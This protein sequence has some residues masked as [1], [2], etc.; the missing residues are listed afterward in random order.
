MRSARGSK[1][2]RE[3]GGKRR[4]EV[5][6]I[7][8]AGDGQWRSWI[9]AQASRQMRSWRAELEWERGRRRGREGQ[10][11][12]HTDMN[13]HVDMLNG[14]GAA[15]GP[16]AGQEQHAN[17]ALMSVECRCEKVKGNS[18][19]RGMQGVSGARSNSSSSSSWGS[20]S[21]GARQSE[22]RS[23]KT[24]K[25]HTKP[26]ARAKQTET[27]GKAAEWGE[28]TAREREREREKVVRKGRSD[29][30][31]TIKNNKSSRSRRCDSSTFGQAAKQLQL[32]SK[33]ANQMSNTIAHEHTHMH[34][35]TVATCT[36][37][38]CK[39]NGFSCCR[40]TRSHSPATLPAT[41]SGKEGVG[42]CEKYWDVGPA[43][44][45][46]SAWA[47]ASASACARA[48]EVEVAGAEVDCWN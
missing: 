32:Q 43:T 46:D 18:G 37:Q 36:W 40:R 9:A 27:V 23:F 7:G 12:Q 2:V 28:R 15:A 13:V 8:R 21:R 20:S 19:K 44:G 41:S 24:T 34:T 16:A 35:H 29:R 5:M 11:E 45:W 4:R 42:E 30:D 3:E 1:R 33:K 22:A 10:S 39:S 26:F 31:G 47:S 6:H 17:V 25:P 14:H 38:D 48:E